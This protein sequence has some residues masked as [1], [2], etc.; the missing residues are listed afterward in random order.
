MLARPMRWLFHLNELRVGLWVAVLT[1]GAYLVLI[2]TAPL[3]ILEGQ[4]LDLRFQ[5]RGSIAP[6]GDILIVQIDDRSIAEIGR[7]P[8]TR[9]RFAEAVDWLTTAGARVIAFDLLFTEPQD[10]VAIDSLK[11]VRRALADLDGTAPSEHEAAITSLREQVQ[12]V[13]RDLDPDGT[14]QDAVAAAGNVVLPFS[15]LFYAND[16]PARRRARAPSRAVASWSYPKALSPGDPRPRLSLRPDNLLPPVNRIAKRAASGGHVN[17]GRE[18]DGTTRYEYPVL[19][20]QGRLYPSLA[21]QAARMALGIEPDEVE[22]V[23]GEGIRLGQV[24]VPT[25]SST[26]AVVNFYGPNRTIPIHSFIDVINGKVEPEVFRDKIVLIGANALAIK[27]EFVT[28]FSPNLTGTERLAVIV[29]NV[30]R[31]RFVIRQDLYW[32]IDAATAIAGGVILGLAAAHIAAYAFSFFAVGLGLAVVAGNQAMFALEDVWLNLTLPLASLLV[33]YSA[34]TIYRYLVQE[35]SAR[36]IRAAFSHYIHPDL[37]RKLAAHPEQLVLG[38]EMRRM[39]FLFA[40]VRGFTT[41]AEHFKS[42]P[43]GLTSLINRFLTPMT[44]T[45]MA[46]GGTIDK[47]IGDCIMAFWNAPLDDHEHPRHACEAALAMISQL[48]TLNA[49]L[50][51]E[52]HESG[53]SHHPI[54]I[55]VGLNTGECCVGNMGSQQRFDYSVLGDSVNLAARLEA[56]SKVYGVDIVIGPET[57]A[58]VPDL[59]AFELD[60]VAVKGRSEAA[61]IHGLIGDREIAAGPAFQAFRTVHNAMLVAYRSRDWPLAERLIGE[62][63]TFDYGPDHFYDI[64][65]DRIAAHREAPPPPEWDGTFVAVAK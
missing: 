36:E 24:W 26:R 4:A 31:E 57:Q 2:E 30:L 7:W 47:Y 6:A 15:F 22:V 44:D 28:P 23:F 59:A 45:I 27:D 13:S 43:Q 16:D 50:E 60:R 14:L 65:R 18:A 25:D 8:W 5:L 51:R 19:E 62:C 33:S 63:R 9:T 37:V 32:L 38:G 29:D 12:A 58:E 53:N 41:I 35:R 21:V 55:G 11:A 39:S 3:R 54:R 34:L 46:R 10:T 61:A 1:T 64:Y 40:D 48:G 49:T 42:D 17:V 20:Y 56:Q 52:A